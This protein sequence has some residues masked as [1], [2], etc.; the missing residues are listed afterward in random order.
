M[1][2]T[3]L[4]GV[5]DGTVDAVVEKTLLDTLL[6]GPD[7][8]EKIATL[9]SNVPVNEK[10]FLHQRKL[11]S[12]RHGFPFPFFEKKHEKT[13]RITLSHSDRTRCTGSSSRGGSTSA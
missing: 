9:W 2:A 3:A 4:D 6:C 5:P 7:R 13:L 8:D 10:L 11:H 12:D 1:D